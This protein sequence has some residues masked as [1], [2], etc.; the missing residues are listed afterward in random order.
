MRVLVVDPTACDGCR[1]CEIVCSLKNEG[2]C[3]P[4]ISRIRVV[5][6]EDKGVFVPVTCLHCEDAPCIRVCPVRA[7]SRDPKTNAVVVDGE[8]CVGCRLC[9]YVCPLG[10]PV[11]DPE[12]GKVVK[13]DLCGGDPTCVRFCSRKAI[14]YVPAEKLSA[15]R[16]R[17]GAD[18]VMELMKTMGIPG[19]GVSGG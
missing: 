15:V 19:L 6:Y 10:T 2:A 11:F 5:R 9:V 1:V 8:L 16:K 12:R 13:C 3:M 4:E 18:V 14:Q 7:L 17:A